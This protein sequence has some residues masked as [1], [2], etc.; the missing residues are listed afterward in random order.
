MALGGNQ[1]CLRLLRGIKGEGI[2][3]NTSEKFHS[4]FNF[5]M[6]LLMLCLIFFFRYIIDNLF[7]NSL[8]NSNYFLFALEN[9]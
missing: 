2:H 7:K 5:K 1:A 3:M 4:Y 8:F 6:V 9:I